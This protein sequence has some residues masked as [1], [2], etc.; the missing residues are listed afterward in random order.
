M[1]DHTIGNNQGGQGRDTPKAKADIRLKVLLKSIWQRRAA[2]SQSLPSE[3]QARGRSSKGPCRAASLRASARTVPKDIPARGSVQHRRLPDVTKFW[4]DQPPPLPSCSPA[5]A[6]ELPR[7]APS[8][9]SP[10]SGSAAPHQPACSLQKHQ[11]ST[12]TLF[13]GQVWR[14]LQLADNRNTPLLLTGSIAS[15]HAR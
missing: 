8:S 6:Q 9:G 5:P 2:H 11:R 10:A 12:Q 13:C 4:Q 15:D 7:D 1:G 14:V 3:L